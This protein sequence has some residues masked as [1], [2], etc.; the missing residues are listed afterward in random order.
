MTRI[1]DVW[2]DQRLVGQLTQ[3]QHGELGFAY[4]TEWVSDDKA[5]HLSASLPER[6]E[7]FS[8][9]ECRPFFGGL[10]PPQSALMSRRSNLVSSEIE[11]FCSSNAMIAPLTA[12]EKGLESN[13]LCL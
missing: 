4:A 7:P 10:L 11:P 6:T 5:Q 9:R 13:A 12:T 8:H 1:L 3:N 2:W